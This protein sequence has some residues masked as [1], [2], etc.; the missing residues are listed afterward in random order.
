M[1]IHWEKEATPSNKRSVI[2]S[3]AF[4]KKKLLKGSS[5]LPNLA[6]KSLSFLHF[7]NTKPLISLKLCWHYFGLQRGI[8]KC[9]FSWK[10]HLFVFISTYY[11]M[12]HFINLHLFLSSWNSP[13]NACHLQQTARNS[14]IN[15][16]LSLCRIPVQTALPNGWISQLLAASLIFPTPWFL[17][18]RKE[19]TR[20]LPRR[21]KESK[22]PT[23]LTSRN[24]VCS[25]CML[26]Q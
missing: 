24:T 14:D 3:L 20:S 19:A 1:H 16:P 18:R 13:T 5:K 22:Y 8:V 26:K 10:K 21:T 11:H 12:K 9:D 7:I 17:R 25:S 2:K 6:R 23:A 4:L 15:V